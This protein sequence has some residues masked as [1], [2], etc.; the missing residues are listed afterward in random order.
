[1]QYISYSGLTAVATMA[2][3]RFLFS[4][5]GDSI[6]VNKGPLVGNIVNDLQ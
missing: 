1:M 4:L 5:L 6:S 3:V 2:N